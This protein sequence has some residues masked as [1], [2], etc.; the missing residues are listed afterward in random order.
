MTQ[1]KDWPD[2]GNDPPAYDAGIG[3]RIFVPTRLL[4]LD[5]QM[6]EVTEVDRTTGEA[7]T[8]KMFHVV[9]PSAWRRAAEVRGDTPRRDS[10]KQ[11]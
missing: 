3:D 2:E 7:H 11:R 9:V 8:E 10:E 1:R 5:Q 4:A 6:V